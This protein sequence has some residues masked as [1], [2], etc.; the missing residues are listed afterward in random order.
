[1]LGVRVRES[2]TP[3]EL[4]D[5]LGGMHPESA[6]TLGALAHE[7]TDATFSPG[8]VA[9]DRAEKAEAL[10]N[11]LAADARARTSTRDWWLHHANPLNVWRDRAGLWGNLRAS[12]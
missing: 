6:E 12:R 4:V 5:R 7:V 8:T 2:D 10:S 3:N 9:S 11:R 1:M